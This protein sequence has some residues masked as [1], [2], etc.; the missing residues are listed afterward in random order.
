MTTLA[1]C[2]VFFSSPHFFFIEV[3]IRSIKLMSLLEH[4][5]GHQMY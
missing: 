2:V 1:G 4:A 5:R 3:I